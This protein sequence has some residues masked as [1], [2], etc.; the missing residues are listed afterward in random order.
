LLQLDL[1]LVELL[2]LRRRLLAQVLELDP[3]E[4]QVALVL[5]R[6]LRRRRLRL[7]VVR[8]AAAVVVG[9][10]AQLSRVRRAHRRELP[11][12]LLL[13]R[14]RRARCEPERLLELLDD[15]RRQL[16]AALEG[17]LEVLCGREHLRGR[18][19]A[20]A[21]GESEAGGEGGGWGG[22]EGGGECR[23]GS[24]APRRRCG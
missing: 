6:L 10:P 12:D 24:E 14:E 5:L 4:H 13:H 23:A 3:R 22:G 7:E 17:L 1:A 2:G 11:V 19:H 18:Q 9:P 20:A 15:E 16:L 8:L 21:E